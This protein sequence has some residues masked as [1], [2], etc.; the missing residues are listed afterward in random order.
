MILYSGKEVLYNGC[1]GCSFANH[2]WQ[3]PCGMAY[4][5]DKFTISQD[6]E[7]PIVGFYV[8]APKRHVNYLNE[9][10]ADEQHEMMNLIDKMLQILKECVTKTYIVMFEEREHIHLHICL[11]PRLDWMYKEVGDAIDNLGAV[12]A[13]SKSNHRNI[14]VF[15]EIDKVTK[16]V[17][18]KMK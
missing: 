17:Q 1:P 16:I 4:E 5:S 6:W 15:K 14:E 7:L 10:T 8:I 9:L 18:D 2:E 11:M 13:Y 12:I 3:L